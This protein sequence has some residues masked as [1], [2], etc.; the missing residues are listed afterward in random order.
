MYAG[1]V[2]AVLKGGLLVSEKDVLGTDSFRQPDWFRDNDGTL[3]PL[4]DS[5]NALF[6]HWLQSQCC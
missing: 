2:W 1:Q 5:C 3:K 6:A 4:L